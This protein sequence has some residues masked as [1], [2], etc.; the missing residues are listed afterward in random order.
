MFVE[1]ILF[2]TLIQYPCFVSQLHAIFFD[3]DG[4]WFLND[5]T[6]LFWVGFSTGILPVSD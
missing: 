5:V 3:Y 4:A 1:S 6:A 2:T